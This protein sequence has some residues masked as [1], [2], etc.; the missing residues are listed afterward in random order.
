MLSLVSLI[1]VAMPVG[2]IVFQM[3]NKFIADAISSYNE[4]FSNDAL[5]F[6]ISSLVVSTPIFY[7]VNAQIF[8]SLRKGE[9]DKDSAVRKWLIYLILFVSSVVMIGWL[10]GVIN[11]YL[12]GGLTVKFILKFLTV[13]IIAG[14]IFSF[15]L[16]DVR[17][18]QVE[19]GKDKVISIYFYSTLAI[20]I[21]VLVSAFLLIDTPSQVRDRNA[22]RENISRLRDISYRIENYA[23]LH[24]KLPQSLEEL[25]GE[26]D[27]LDDK[28]IRHVMTNNKFEYRSKEKGKYE[29]C[30]YFRLSSEEMEDKGYYANNNWWHKKGKHCFAKTVNF[31]ESG[32]NL[33]I[34]LRD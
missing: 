19:G 12:S 28:K 4:T 5:R 16:Y 14:I 26:D 9:L 32:D 10:I 18:E 8:K 33:P 21:V 1:F 13:F 34:K 3:I 22:D 31:D 6:A 20:V 7:V 25:A 30:A 27:F 29:L 17:R 24:E 11:V 23:K 15:Y 2:M